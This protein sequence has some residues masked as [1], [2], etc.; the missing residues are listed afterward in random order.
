MFSSIRSS[1][2]LLSLAAAATLSA[3]TPGSPLPGPNGPPPAGG[4]GGSAQFML[5]HTG[6]LDLTDAQVVKLAAIA[7][8]SEARRRAGRAAMD[9]ART[10]FGPQSAPADSSARRQFRDRM[11][12]D[13]TRLR[14]QAQVDQRD[15]I[16][17]L[18]ADQQARAWNMV[19]ARG[20]GMG[21]E[22]GMK[23]G[24]GRG[25][26]GG[27]GGMGRGMRRRMGGPGQLGPGGMGRDVRPPRP[28][29]E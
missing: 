2:A 20:R 3:Q 8:R 19:S 14:D 4:R 17:V 28:P 16:A 25:M 21:A 1:V 13:F 9:S 24:M 23:G 6:E 12:S 15:A 10:R 26:G 22:G 29:Q 11:R 7:R 27:R 18:T 5:A